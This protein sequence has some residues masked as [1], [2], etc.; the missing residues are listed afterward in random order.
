MV[1]GARTRALVL[2]T[3]PTARSVPVLAEN[4]R[5][6]CHQNECPGVLP[7]VQ[8]SPAGFKDARLHPI[9]AGRQAWW[10]FPRGDVAILLPVGERLVM[11]HP[12]RHSLV[13]VEVHDADDQAVAQWSDADLTF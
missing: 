6:G 13:D 12:L 3:A 5:S 1:E 11:E 4:A 2:A 10:D 7:P 9:L 8:R